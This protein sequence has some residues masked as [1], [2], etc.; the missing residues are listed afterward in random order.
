MITDDAH[1][2]AGQLLLASHL[3]GQVADDEQ[4]KKAYLV[5]DAS[6]E[7]KLADDVTNAQLFVTRKVTLHDGSEVTVKS[8]FQCLK[9]AAERMTLEEYSERCQVPVKTIQSLGR[10][11]TSYDRQAAVISMVG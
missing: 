3:N 8:S 6:G 7:L 1:P 2:L 5:Q 10:A 9:E 11:L 4:S